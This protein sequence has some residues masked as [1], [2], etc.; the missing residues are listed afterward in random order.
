MLGG[1]RR[2]ARLLVSAHR[3]CAPRSLATRPVKRSLLSHVPKALVALDYTGTV[4]F[5]ASGTLV[6]GQAGMDVLGCAF[7]GTVTA[8]GGGTIRDLL[9]GRAPVFW[10]K[11]TGYLAACLATA[12]AT[13]FASEALDSTLLDDEVLWWGDTLGIGAF[14]VVGAQTAAAEGMGPAVTALCGM[15]T[16]TCGGL[17]RD[18]LVRRQPRLLHSAP[19][20]APAAAG[21]LYAPAALSGAAAYTALTRIAPAPAA[22]AAGCATT[23]AVR[24]AG[25]AFNVKLPTFAASDDA[26]EARPA[27]RLDPV[28]AHL[29]VTAYGRDRPG[30]VA[31]LTRTLAA[32]R[33]NISSSKISTIGD[34]IAFMMV[35]SAPRGATGDLRERVKAAGRDHGVAVETHALTPGAGG[36]GAP[37]PERRHRAR[38]EL[39]G[40]DSPGLVFAVSALLRDHGLNIASLDTRVAAPECDAGAPSTR[41]YASRSVTR[42]H[43]DDVFTL[44]A[45][46]TAATMPS[47]A[48]AADAARLR[49]KYLGA[50]GVFEIVFDDGPANDLRRRKSLNRRITSH[51]A[52]DAPL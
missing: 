34:D 40:P 15:F 8:L 3:R 12:L 1:S 24:L 37:P 38:V 27:P 52:P 43:D 10:F 41:A 32:S 11:E 23:V 6:A 39:S 19:K 48:L 14:S 42:R 45:V 44:S 50:A 16:A 9:L 17:V 5:A 47:D 26:F 28:D 21:T 49:R 33:A 4:A 25:Y 31:D 35:V 18:V 13:F 20:D 36:R 22:I 7:V 29:F 51:A 46:V 2:A 30:L